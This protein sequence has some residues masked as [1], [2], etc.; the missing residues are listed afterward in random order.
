MFVVLFCFQVNL[1]WAFPLLYAFLFDFTLSKFFLV[2]SNPPNPE[3]FG[4]NYVKK[5]NSNIRRSV[6]SAKYNKGH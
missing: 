1:F 3:R 4:L 2:P 5:P 6:P